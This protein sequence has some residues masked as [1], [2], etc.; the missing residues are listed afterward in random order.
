M[1]DTTTTITRADRKAANLVLADAMRAYGLIPNGKVWDDTKALVAFGL[2]PEAA[3][4]L[5]RS[6]LPE[7]E[8]VA[9]IARA[10]GKA[11]APKREVVRSREVSNKEAARIMR[12]REVNDLA[13]ALVKATGEAVPNRPRAHE[14]AQAPIAQAP[15]RLSSRA[16]DVKAG[17][18]LRDSKG[19]LVSREVQE[20]FSSLRA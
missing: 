11:K 15:K 19:R 4:R 2:E 14:V 10:K 9:A 13:A 1:S 17:K 12:E 18:V 20:A 8:Q 7:A 16:K 5:T 6:L 3:A